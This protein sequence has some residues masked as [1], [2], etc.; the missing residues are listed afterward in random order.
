[1]NAAF[2]S[3]SAHASVMLLHTVFYYPCGFGSS[4]GG[5]E[6]ASMKSTGTYFGNRPTFLISLV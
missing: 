6:P 3:V 1:M 5:S 2:P 4:R